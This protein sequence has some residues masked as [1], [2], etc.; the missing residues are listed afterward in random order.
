MKG[1]WKRLLLR[2]IPYLITGYFFNRLAFLWWHTRGQ[3]FARLITV[4]DHLQD[5]LYY[6]LPSLAAFDLMIGVLGAGML[7]LAVQLK[8]QN[9][10]KFRHGREYGSAR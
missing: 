1:E 4:F 8:R 9:R 7:F 6:P 3:P 10:K 2:S 5:I